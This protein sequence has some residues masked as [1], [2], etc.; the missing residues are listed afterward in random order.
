MNNETS[1]P[2]GGGNRFWLAHAAAQVN[3]GL[4]RAE[5]C[6]QHQLSYHTLTYWQKKSPKTND[7]SEGALVAVPASAL[8]KA[9]PRTERQMRVVLPNNIIIELSNTFSAAAL[10]EL[11][12]VVEK[13]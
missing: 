7:K 11:L 5:Y 13:R 6:R 1:S 4:S 8:K 12:N 9:Q 2:L 3:S 10:S